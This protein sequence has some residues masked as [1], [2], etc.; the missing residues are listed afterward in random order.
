MGLVLMGW[1]GWICN[2]SMRLRLHGVLLDMW[3]SL[4]QKKVWC[5]CDRDF[6]ILIPIS[7]CMHERGWMYGVGTGVGC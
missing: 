4:E 5:G 1:I 2:V 7:I 3:I 6:Q